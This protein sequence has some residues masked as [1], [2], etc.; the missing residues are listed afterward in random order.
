MVDCGL[1]G[2]AALAGRTS[3]HRIAIRPRRE[4][5]A[6]LLCLHCASISTAGALSANVGLAYRGALVTNSDRATD[7]AVAPFEQ[8]ITAIASQDHGPFGE[9]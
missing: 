1:A 7:G 4:N 8:W 6:I 5:Q 2:G 3:H 9:I